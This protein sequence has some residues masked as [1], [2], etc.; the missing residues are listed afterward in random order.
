MKIDVDVR[1]VE[2]CSRT[3]FL[4]DYRI[5]T[6][7]MK[8]IQE[9]RKSLCCFKVDSRVFVANR[10]LLKR[11]LSGVCKVDCEID[12]CFVNVYNDRPEISTLVCLKA[13]HL[14]RGEG[15]DGVISICKRRYS[16]LD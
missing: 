9:E 4:L 13:K 14:A 12:M 1:K 3:A 10:Q 16:F 11:K 7:E 15:T 5:S 8:I 2:T 6:L